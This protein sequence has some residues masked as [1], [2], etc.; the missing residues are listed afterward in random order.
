VAVV[1]QLAQAG[2]AQGLLAE[3]NA[4]TNTKQL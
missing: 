2:D 1:I 3:G 4:V